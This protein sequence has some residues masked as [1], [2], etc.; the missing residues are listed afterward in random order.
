MGPNIL[1]KRPLGVA[2]PPVL[3]M[4]TLPLRVLPPGPLLPLPLF[5]SERSLL[6]PLAN[7]A[8]RSALIT[9]S[10]TPI[11]LS[12]SLTKVSPPIV[13]IAPL[14]QSYALYPMSIKLVKPFKNFPPRSITKSITPLINGIN[15]VNFGSIPINPFT[16][17]AKIILPINV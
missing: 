17:N 5:L 2:D 9:K 7:V 1:P 4:G 8:R 15:P 16:A 13:F 12:N 11:N 3:V 10:M 6:K 14:V